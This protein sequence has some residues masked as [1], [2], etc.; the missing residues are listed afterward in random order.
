MARFST[1]RP[2]LLL[3][4]AT[5][6]ASSLTWADQP[7]PEPADA[8]VQAALL[9]LDSPDFANREAAQQDLYRLATTEPTLRAM[10]VE[11]AE[12]HASDEVRARAAVVLD[13]LEE[14]DRFGETR[15]TLDIDGTADDALAA[16]L[17]L[18]DI[19]AG[20]R[21]SPDQDD[22]RFNVHRRIVAD[23]GDPD[24]AQKPLKLVLDDV[25]FWDAVEAIGEAINYW[26]GEHDHP[27]VWRDRQTLGI[28]P[29]SLVGE[30]NDD[31]VGYVPAA[32]VELMQATRNRNGSMEFVRNDAGDI[33]P[34]RSN[35]GQALNLQLR[36]LVEPKLLLAGNQQSLVVDE[37][38]D[39]RGNNLAPPTEQSRHHRHYGRSNRFF[40]LVNLPLDAEAGAESEM[41]Q[42]L[43]GRVILTVAEGRETFETD[44]TEEAESLA[45]KVTDDNGTPQQG[46][47]QD[48]DAWSVPVGA[49]GQVGDMQ[50]ELESL[51]I[52]N[53]A[54][55][56]GMLQNRAQI[57]RQQ[58]REL[59]AADRLPTLSLRFVVDTA[60]RDE[61]R[62]H[63]DALKVLDTDGRAWQPSGSRWRSHS[64]VPGKSMFTQTFTDW[65]GQLD[66]PARV[67]WTIPTS[68]RDLSVPFAFENVPLP[69]R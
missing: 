4:A 47:N 64:E 63:A 19:D 12:D 43:S 29:V 67:V 65:S 57:R 21:P 62:L 33:N 55:L 56:Q 69:A 61:L 7:T 52:E 18:L 15:V 53:P 50:F 11:A 59:D 17:S 66:P 23:W 6:L 25:P 39:E 16:L 34:S 27:Q 49:Q 32:R 38:I 30:T 28:R 41:L 14:R 10:I 44:I 42:R 48:D 51:R 2:L 22:Q 24:D 31:V 60:D 13:L 37:A 9:A 8:E 20:E 45:V 54:A 5:C 1:L 35:T 3:T 40:R 26:P 46:M 68:T 36:L 58:E